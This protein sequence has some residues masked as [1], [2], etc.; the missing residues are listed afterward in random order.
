MYQELGVKDSNMFR[1]VLRRVHAKLQN[2]KKKFENNL[3]QCRILLL[4]IPRHAK[5]G[6]C[7]LVD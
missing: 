5:R 2:K 1:E 3:T 4:D 7:A 6:L